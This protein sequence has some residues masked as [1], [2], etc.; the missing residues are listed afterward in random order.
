[1]DNYRDPLGIDQG[2]LGSKHFKEAVN[3]R[4]TEKCQQI[5]RKKKNVRTNGLKR[6]LKQKIIEQPPFFFN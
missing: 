4:L 3:M 6:H 2:T 1:M 5:K